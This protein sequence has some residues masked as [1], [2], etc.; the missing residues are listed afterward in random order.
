[1]E[2][3]TANEAYR[4]AREKLDRRLSELNH[5]IR[6]HAERQ[7][8]DRGNWGYAGDLNHLV[9]VVDGLLASLGATK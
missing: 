1:M 5:R 2:T 4:A 6:E 8:K 9:E 3:N 7:Y